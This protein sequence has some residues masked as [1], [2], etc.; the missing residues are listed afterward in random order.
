MIK[1]KQQLWGLFHYE[2]IDF[3]NINNKGYNFIIRNLIDLIKLKIDKIID[4]LDEK[5]TEE[6]DIKS[7]NKFDKNKI[8]EKY[9]DKFNHWIDRA[10]STYKYPKGY[11][12]TI[13]SIK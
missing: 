8:L 5:T 12:F 13:T 2:T 9:K 10:N 4:N 11:E 1:Q 6:E 3:Y 7:I